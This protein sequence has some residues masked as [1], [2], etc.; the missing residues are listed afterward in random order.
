MPCPHTAV[1]RL[2]PPLVSL[3]VFA[4]QQQIGRWEWWRR[5]GH[6]FQQHRVRLRG[7]CRWRFWASSVGWGGWLVNSEI[8]SSAFSMVAWGLWRW[9]GLGQ[10]PVTRL[11]PRICEFRVLLNGMQHGAFGKGQVWASF[12]VTRL[13]ERGLC[14]PQNRLMIDHSSI[15]LRFVYVVCILFYNL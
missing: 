5:G 2:S 7:S 11:G 14:F 13:G 1:F 12:R 6:W 3:V 8:S 9:R 4:T 10:L 15:D